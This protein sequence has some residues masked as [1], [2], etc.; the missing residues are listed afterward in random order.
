VFALSL[1][2]SLVGL[3]LMGRAD[4]PRHAALA[5]PAVGT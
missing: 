5:R 2:L 4:E 1:A 3:L